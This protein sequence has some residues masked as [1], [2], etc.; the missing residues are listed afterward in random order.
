MIAAGKYSLE[1]DNEEIDEQRSAEDEELNISLWHSQ[2]PASLKTLQ[3]E[4]YDDDSGIPIEPD[5]SRLTRLSLNQIARLKLTYIH[6]QG[7]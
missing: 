2:L 5:D 7:R 1:M 3:A 4:I 6:K